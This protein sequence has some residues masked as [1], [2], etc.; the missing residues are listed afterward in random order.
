MSKHSTT[1][2]TLSR[3]LAAL[4]TAMALLAAMALPVYAEVDLLP[5]AHDEVE[6]L[7]DETGTASGEDTALPEQ[8]LSL[9][10]I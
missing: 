1:P 6:L 7:E 4:L 10:H 2:R 8:N 3:R 5:D 9:I